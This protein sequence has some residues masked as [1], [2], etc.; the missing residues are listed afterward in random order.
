MLQPPMKVICSLI[1][2]HVKKVYGWREDETALILPRVDCIIR[3][4]HKKN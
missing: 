3:N 4:E 2:N 1:L